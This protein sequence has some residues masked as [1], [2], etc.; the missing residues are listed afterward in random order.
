M[1]VVFVSVVEG[2]DSASFLSLSGVSVTGSLAVAVVA[3]VVVV[4]VGVLSSRTGWGGPDWDSFMTAE[5]GRSK[6]Y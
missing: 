2:V 3:A 6:E 5:G 4:V 1:V